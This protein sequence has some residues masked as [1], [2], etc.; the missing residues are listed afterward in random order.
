[1]P[2]WGVH[3][4]LSCKPLFY[5]LFFNFPSF[6]VEQLWI[7]MPP[8]WDCVGW[9]KAYKIHLLICFLKWL[10]GADQK[11]HGQA[12]DMYRSER[13]WFPRMCQD[14]HSIL[15]TIKQTNKQSNKQN[16]TK[17]PIVWWY[18][19]WVQLYLLAG[20]VCM[21]GSNS[22]SWVRSHSELHTVLSS[23]KQTNKQAT[24]FLNVNRENIWLG[25]H[26]FSL[27]SH[28]NSPV[29]FAFGPCYFYL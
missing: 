11:L 8:V 12:E 17:N 22:I 1:L 13:E 10:W 14:P 18:Q 16:K 29:V 24:F 2:R 7:T 21:C 6:Q 3:V 9:A 23:N 20:V 19:L 4:K 5:I 15:S 27:L 25:S 26:L 28:L